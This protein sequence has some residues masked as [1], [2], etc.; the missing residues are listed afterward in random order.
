MKAVISSKRR[1]E[2]TQPHGENSNILSA[3][4]YYFSL[5]A[6]SHPDDTQTVNRY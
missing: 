1:E 5:S 2:I 6:T 4:W 3:Y